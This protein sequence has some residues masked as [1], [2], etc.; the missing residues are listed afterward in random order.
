MQKREGRNSTHRRDDSG[1]GLT[2]SSARPSPGGGSSGGLN[3]SMSANG[4]G[5]QRSAGT[6]MPNSSGN[7]G[8]NG[9]AMNLPPS[10]YRLSKSPRTRSPSPSTCSLKASPLPIP[11]ETIFT[12]PPRAEASTSAVQPG[13]AAAGRR[14]RP[15]ASQPVLN[16]W[17]MAA[18]Q[19]H[20]P[21][22]TV[23]NAARGTPSSMNDSEVTQDAEP[24]YD[25]PSF[26]ARPRTASLK[27]V[28]HYQNGLHD[29][30]TNQRDPIDSAKENR[31][32]SSTLSPG[33]HRRGLGK[34]QSISSF[35]GMPSATSSIGWIGQHILSRPPSE[36]GAVSSAAAG[37]GGLDVVVAADTA[38]TNTVVTPSTAASTASSTSEAMAWTDPSDGLVFWQEGA[39]QSRRDAPHH[40]RLCSLGEE[41]DVKKT[42]VAKRTLQVD[43][44]LAQTEFRQPRRKRDSVDLRASPRGEMPLFFVPPGQVR[45]GSPG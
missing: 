22:G 4:D 9:Y 12:F 40:Q 34:S 36:R 1:A 13:E 28:H 21:L 26:R 39:D 33:R 37:T 31:P 10:S 15:I 44:R 17:K 30:A 5:R 29:L 45:Q 14:L 2:P 3:G 6:R 25:P 24:D 19:D 18:L 27:S 23:V 32:R 43:T 38:S 7:G 35:F 42:P 41:N 8:M 20:V 11:E 16:G